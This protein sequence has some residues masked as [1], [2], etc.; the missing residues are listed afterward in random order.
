MD[1]DKINALYYQH[2]E[3]LNEGAT[4]PNPV[5]FGRVHTEE[6]DAEDY[7]PGMGFPEFLEKMI[8]ILGGKEDPAHKLRR[9][10]RMGF[11]AKKALGSEDNEAEEGDGGEEGELMTHMKQQ[12][13]IPKGSKPSA[14]YSGT[15]EK[16]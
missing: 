12:G 8:S 6:E 7:V 1:I 9:I 5:S 16:R 11:N 15:R 2:R 13:L 14:I 3:Q 4:A 10:A